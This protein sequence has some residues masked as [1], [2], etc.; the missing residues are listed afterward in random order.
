MGV[1]Q[2]KFPFFRKLCLKE[3]RFLDTL[4]PNL[5]MFIDRALAR[6]PLSAACSRQLHSPPA[7]TS[8]HTQLKAPLLPLLAR[9][10]LH[11]PTSAA[12]QTLRSPARTSL[13]LHFTTTQQPLTEACPH[14]DPFSYHQHAFAKFSNPCLP[15]TLR[16]DVQ[17][18]PSHHPSPV[19]PHHLA[20]PCRRTAIRLY[21]RAVQ[22][23]SAI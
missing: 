15:S 16:G 10:S 7:T 4:R 23:Q 14:K 11:L 6:T 22:V 17:P 18:S 19:P 13:P 3:L 5:F 9:Q 2:E 21:S 12:N 20:L 1:Q 8:I